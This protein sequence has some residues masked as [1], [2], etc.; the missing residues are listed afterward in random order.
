MG[1]A[2]TVA[3]LA[4]AAI[5]AYTAY[6]THSQAVSRSDAAAAAAAAAVRQRADAAKTAALESHMNDIKVDMTKNQ[7]AV[8]AK[9]AEITSLQTRIRAAGGKV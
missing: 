1:E 7:T 6:N 5:G 3:A 4:P 2:A 9:Q 8:S